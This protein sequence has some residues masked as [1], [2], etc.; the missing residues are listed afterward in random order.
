MAKKSDKLS[1]WSL[2]LNTFVM[3]AFTVGGG[4]VMIPLMRE[5]FVEKLGWID[6]D[7]LTELTAL[8]QSAPG[9]MI[10]NSTAI[11]GYRLLGFRGAV[12]AVLGTALPSV[13]VLAV[14]STFYELIRDNAYVSAAFRGMR[15]GVAAVI[16]DTVVAMA[17]PYFRRET[18]V[19]VVIMAGAF[20]VAFALNVNVAFIIIGCGLF[21]II[22]GAVQRKRGKTV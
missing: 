6:Q 13:I 5:R 4:Y 22:L 18:A 20:L 7:E 1:Y 8:G 9:A 16:A 19:S 2:F 11:M 15:A 21:G 10:I 12:C 14:I 3:S 17:A